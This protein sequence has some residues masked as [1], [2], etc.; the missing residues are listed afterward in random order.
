MN[1]KTSTE[2]VKTA[3]RKEIGRQ[4][5]KSASTRKIIVEA[6]LS[7]IAKYGYAGTTT[8]IIANEAGVSRGAMMH[9]F[10]NRSAVIG[11]AIE[12]LHE[13]R[14][15][16]FK[17]AI[18]ALPKDKL[19][20]H[21]GL[22]AYWKH[23]THPLYVVFHELAVASRTDKGL[24]KILQPAQA[25]FYDEWYNLSYDLF[26]QWRSNTAALELAM[27]LV[28]TTLEGVAIRHLSI[29][30]DIERETRLFNYLEE[31][32]SALKPKL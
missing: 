14:L 5:Q 3:Q 7:C 17:R 13:K 25:A 16:A 4:A 32:L 31:C 26:P 28:N 24:A 21:D 11:A 19:Q 1:S 30:E 2:K 27:D 15:R 12:Y 20:L 8:P 18:A 23:V 9:H 6:A 29:P 10:N 22:K